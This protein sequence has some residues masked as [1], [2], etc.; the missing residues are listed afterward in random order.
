M[1]KKIYTNSDRVKKWRTNTKIRCLKY[2]GGSCIICGYNKCNRAMCF[3]HIDPSKKE[4]G[5]AEPCTISWFR[6]RNELKKCVL[7][8]VRC[9]AE[10]HDG[11]INIGPY[12]INDMNDDSAYKKHTKNPP[13]KCTDCG[14]LISMTAKR[15]Q[16]CHLVM[17]RK[18]EWPTPNFLSQLLETT[19]LVEIGKLYGVSDNSIRKWCISYKIDYKS[20]SP[21]S[22][23]RNIF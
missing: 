13:N 12:L 6:I 5:I 9:H 22:H 21:Y 3:H 14:C 4:F 11:S 20:I 1:N 7:L 8:C 18:V 16:K 10:V 2:K 17:S 19:S 23:R 15:C